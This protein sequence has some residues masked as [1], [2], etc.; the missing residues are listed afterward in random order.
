MS[1]KLLAKHGQKKQNLMTGLERWEIILK[2]IKYKLRNELIQ[3]DWEAG[4]N[5]IQYRIKNVKNK[6]Y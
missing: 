6:R 2:K 4:T 1:R 3:A 5:L